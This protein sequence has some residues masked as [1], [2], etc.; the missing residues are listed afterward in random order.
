MTTEEN[1]AN[2]YIRLPFLYSTSFILPLRMSY[3]DT[4]LATTSSRF[5]VASMVSWLITAVLSLYVCPHHYLLIAG[6]GNKT[7][8]CLA[9]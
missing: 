2:S 6:T 4:G 3:V 9:T 5:R 1:V 8:S 7:Q